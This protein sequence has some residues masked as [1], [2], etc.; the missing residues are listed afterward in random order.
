MDLNLTYA[1]AANSSVVPTPS[2]PSLERIAK[3]KNRTS[4][5]WDTVDYWE[6]N[7][8]IS[9]KAALI[10]IDKLVVDLLPKYKGITKLAKDNSLVITNFILTEL[11]PL[12]LAISPAVTQCKEIL[13]RTLKTDED[14]SPSLDTSVLDQVYFMSNEAVK[15][16]LRRFI[17]KLYSLKEFDLVKEPDVLD[18][19]SRSISKPIVEAITNKTSGKNELKEALDHLEK[20]QGVN[21]QRKTHAR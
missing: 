5:F 15:I 3:R 9:K 10:T 17:A 12:T 11:A 2:T 1:T 19:L 18:K 6:P 4:R 16:R 13:N 8:E 14:N 21:K 7:K 20:M